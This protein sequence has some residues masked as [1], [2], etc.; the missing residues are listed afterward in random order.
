MKKTAILFSICFLLFS[1]TKAQDLQETLN[2]LS[3]DAVKS[4]VNPVIS[5]F[6]SNLNSG[7]ASNVPESK[8]FG[9]DIELKILGQASFFSNDAKTFSS[10]GSFRLTSSQADA[11]LSQ[12]GITPSSGTAYTEIK[13]QM[14]A[15]PFDLTIAGPTIVGSKDQEVKITF[16]TKT[17]TTS[18][19]TRTVSLATIS[20]G[21]T[22]VA[23]EVPALPFAA[24]QLNVGTVYGT[25]V[26][27]R[28]IP[29]IPAG[30]LGKFSFWGFGVM[31]NPA[32]YLPFSLPVDVGVGFFYQKMELG[33][34]FQTSATQ[35]GLFASKQFGSLVSITPYVGATLESSSTTLSYDYKYDASVNGVVTPVTLKQ[36]M[37]FNGDNSLGFTVGAKIH[38]LFINIIADYKMASVSTVNGGVS[39]SF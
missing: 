27:L 30:D 22:G 9:L 15:A 29:E 24:V 33:S 14:L 2:N 10:K 21:A 36:S 7:W 13:N 12:S 34:T 28:F 3:K 8:I 25:S 11:I 39:F 38:L 26:A 5:A 1:S 23:G 20:T 31:H 19:G 16:P 18:A 35:F 32:M 6:G 37:D 4:Y 17:F